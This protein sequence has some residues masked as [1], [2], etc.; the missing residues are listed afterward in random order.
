MQIM[1]MCHKKFVFR[2]CHEMF[3]TVTEVSRVLATS[4]DKQVSSSS[5]SVEGRIYC[6]YVDHSQASTFE[7]EVSFLLAIA[8]DFAS[9]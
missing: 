8:I 2:N 7:A 4:N 5:R 6:S 3:R 9:R 1:Q